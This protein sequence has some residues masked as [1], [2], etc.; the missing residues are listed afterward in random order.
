[1]SQPKKPIFRIIVIGGGVAGLAAAVGLQR[2]GHRLLVLESTDTLQT[3]GG[4]LLIPP[5]AARVLDAYGIWET[6][7]KSEDIPLGNVT[8]RYEDG[9]VLEEISYAKM[10]GIFGYPYV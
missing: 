3:L 9:S 4:S 6:F 1:M 10:E 7:K 8:F 2:K 5:S